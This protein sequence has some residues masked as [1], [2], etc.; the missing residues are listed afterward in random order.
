MNSSQFG[1]LNGGTWRAPPPTAGDLPTCHRTRRWRPIWKDSI[2]EAD[3]YDLLMT[4][5]PTWFLWLIGA[6]IPIVTAVVGGVNVAVARANSRREETMRLLRW[7][8]EL[9]VDP[10]SVTT[11]FMGMQAL[12]AL[13]Q[14]GKLDKDDKRI[15]VAITHAVLAPAIAAYPQSSGTSGETAEAAE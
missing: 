12:T 2:A 9:A 11:N 3:R 6:F 8:A 7:A 5:I 1:R 13:A 10:G 14:G 4:E 15:L